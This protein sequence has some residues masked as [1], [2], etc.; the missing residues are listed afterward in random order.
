[1]G[2]CCSSCCGLSLCLFGCVS[3][4]MREG[5]SSV[6]RCVG[7][8]VSVPAAASAATV[9]A[10]ALATDA[11]TT[12]AAAWRGVVK[13]VASVLSVSVELAG[14]CSSVGI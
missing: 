13:C 1:M 8:A 9:D 14:G 5:G 10:A 7:F 2:M 6:V 12:A 11:A 3:V 4:Q